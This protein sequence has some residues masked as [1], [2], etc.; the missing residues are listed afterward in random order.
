MRKQ[1]AR[2]TMAEPYPNR[3]KPCTRC[4]AC[5][6]VCPAA[7]TPSLLHLAIRARDW[8]QVVEL[9][10]DACTECAACE[11][12]CPSAINLVA[13]FRYARADL[14]WQRAELERADSARRRY[15][16]RTRRLSG[17]AVLPEPLVPSASTPTTSPGDS[18]RSLL[19][20]A[21]A[22]SQQRKR[23]S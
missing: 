6:A 13:D 11:P 12:V 17:T 21:L 4:G 18:P 19:Q 14:A 23:Q 5:L 22:R 16:A 9:H 10:I 3:E 2:P 1:R 8:A 20:A 7:L 15:Q